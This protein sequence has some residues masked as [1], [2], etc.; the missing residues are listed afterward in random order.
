MISLYFHAEFRFTWEKKGIL[1]YTSS[2]TPKNSESWKAL[3]AGRV[4]VTNAWG[5]SQDCVIRGGK[6]NL[7]N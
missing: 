2:T 4:V 6:I 1:K 7:L 5:V 3:H